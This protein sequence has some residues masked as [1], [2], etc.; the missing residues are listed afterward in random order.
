MGFRLWYII[1]YATLVFRRRLEHGEN[2]ILVIG[3][4]RDCVPRDIMQL[5]AWMDTSEGHGAHAERFA[6]RAIVDKVP[7]H[8]HTHSVY[9]YDLFCARGA[10]ARS[11]C[12][13]SVNSM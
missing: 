2:A 5:P 10:N 11:T 12:T 9:N 3:I 8:H 4:L 7:I 13:T 6:K 1:P